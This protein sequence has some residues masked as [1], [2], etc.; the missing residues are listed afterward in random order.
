MH[1]LHKKAGIL[2]SKLHP[3]FFPSHE[4]RLRSLETLHF[5]SFYG[6][7]KQNYISY[8][9]IVY[10]KLSVRL[11]T[12]AASVFSVISKITLNKLEITIKIF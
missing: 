6:I 5:S 12:E 11:Y 3:V 1:S 8:I 9:R 4:G 10:Q 2:I 7:L